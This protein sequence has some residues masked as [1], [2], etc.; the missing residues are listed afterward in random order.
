MIGPKKGLYLGGPGDPISRKADLTESIGMLPRLDT[1]R[2]GPLDG[3][4]PTF[5]GYTAKPPI[6]ACQ[7]PRAGGLEET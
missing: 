3:P 1:C 4:R 7:H 2:L 5:P 6:L